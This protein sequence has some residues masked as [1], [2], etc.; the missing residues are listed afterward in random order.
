MVVGPQGMT[1][2][3]PGVSPPATTTAPAARSRRPSP[4]TW[5]GAR[6]VGEHLRG[7]GLRAPGDPRRRHT[8]GSG[9]ATDRSTTSAGMSTMAR[10]ERAPQQPPVSP[11]GAPPPDGGAGAPERGTRSAPPPLAHL[12][13][14]C[15]RHRRAGRRDRRRLRRGSRR[16]H[17]SVGQA[18]RRDDCRFRA[19]ERRRRPAGSCCPAARTDHG[20]RRASDQHRRIP[21]RAPGYEEGRL[22]D[23]PQ[24]H[25]AVRPLHRPRVGRVAGRRRRLLPL[26]VARRRLEGGEHRS[27]IDR[28]RACRYSP[29]RAARTAGTGRRAIVAAP[30]TLPLGGHGGWSGHRLHPVH[31]GA[32]PG[33]PTTD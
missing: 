19:H 25:A 3:R 1:V 16:Q 5:P 9:P 2:L 15:A 32:D 33:A 12:A 21:L 20:S 18:R 26:G 29:R 10:V 27:G 8:G 22:P 6:R 28:A 4:P 24:Q 13:A 17:P 14:A 31:A 23:Q 30:T 11:D 7:Q